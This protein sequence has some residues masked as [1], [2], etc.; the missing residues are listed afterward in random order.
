MVLTGYT[1]T[2]SVL[3][4]YTFYRYIVQQ[5]EYY[6]DF[7]WMHIEVQMYYLISIFTVI[8]NANRIINEVN[9]QKLY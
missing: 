8:Y 6:K 9:E 5:N 3:T 4:Y 1:F 2:L 7:A